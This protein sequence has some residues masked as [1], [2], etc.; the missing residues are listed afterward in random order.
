MMALP[1]QINGQILT[2]WMKAY[3]LPRDHMPHLALLW[4]DRDGEYRVAYGR[5]SA[6]NHVYQRWRNG[7]YE[8]CWP[9]YYCDLGEME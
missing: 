1:R 3:P 6:V 7:K 9:R 4:P 8:V 5:Y 2:N